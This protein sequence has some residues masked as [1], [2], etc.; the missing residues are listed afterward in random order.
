MDRN[1]ST[2]QGVTSKS[3][4]KGQTLQTP[5]GKDSSDYSGK[6]SDEVTSKMKMGGGSKDY[7]KVKGE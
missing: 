3:I 4:G 5:I 6:M 1:N 2:N 7:S